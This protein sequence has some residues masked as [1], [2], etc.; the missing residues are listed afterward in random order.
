MS[1]FIEARVIQKVDTEANWLSNPL[2]LYQG[3]IAFVSDKY[4]FKLNNTD[5]PKTFAELEYYYKG[6][7]LGGVSPTDNLT[8]KPDGV[9]RATIS[10]TYSGVV[11][12]EGYY[13]LLRKD[14]GVWKLESEVKMPRVDVDGNI[15][16]GQTTKAVNGDRIAKY[17][18]NTSFSTFIPA[19]STV[20]YDLDSVV[21][22]HDKLYKSLKPDNKTLPTDAT[23]WKEIKLGIEVDQE[24][25]PT[26]ENAVSPV[27]V[28]NWL[29]GV[30]DE[31]EATELNIQSLFL[32]TGT[33]QPS[34]FMYL[35]NYELPEGNLKKIRI[36]VTSSGN[37]IIRRYIKSGDT[38][39]FKDKKTVNVTTGENNIN[40]DW[41][42]TE[43]SVFSFY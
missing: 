27:A 39:I 28:N 29:Y 18:G 10:G 24:F 31:S 20:G 17:I 4:N 13:T 36:K 43:P 16:V 6:D 38:L 30:E 32:D 42:L 34:G 21:Y 15:V 1:T 19:L 40:L 41:L 3:E 23:K 35:H 33:P 8:S 37:M 26:S 25:I 22:Y 11:V 12:K 2:K 14:N 9:Y 5:V 7:V